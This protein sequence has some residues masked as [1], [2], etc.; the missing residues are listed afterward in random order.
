MEWHKER[1]SHPGICYIG[2]YKRSES[3]S[4]SETIETFGVGIRRHN[5]ESNWAVVLNAG[6]ALH[7]R[8]VRHLH[9]CHPQ[10]TSHALHTHIEEDKSSNGNNLG[11]LE[12][13]Q[14]KV[15]DCLN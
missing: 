5:A 14:V 13:I 2:V 6:K 12:I 11:S 4:I 8:S 10:P 7:L 15:E 1:K 3:Q 9:D